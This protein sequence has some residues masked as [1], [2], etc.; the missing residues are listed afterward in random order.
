MP[1]HAGTNWMNWRKGTTSVALGLGLAAL[2]GGCSA[3]S[4]G[5]GGGGGGST[6]DGT[7]MSGALASTRVDHD[8]WSRLGYRLVWTGYAT[9]SPSD[10]VTAL[11]LFD[12]GIL[13]QDSSSVITD[14]SPVSGE[15]KW[16]TPVASPLTRFVGMTR[17]GKQYVVC[18][19]SEAFFVAADSGTLL[20]KQRFDRVVNT[21]PVNTGAL[22][23]MGTSGG[24]VIGHLLSGFKA[25]AYGVGG[26]FE[27]RPVAVGPDHVGLVSQNGRVIIIMPVT[28]SASAQY[29]I[30]GGVACELAASDRMLFVASVDQS[31]YGFEIYGTGAKWRKRTDSALRTTPTYHDGRLY[32][33]VPSA[34]LMCLEADTGRDIWTAKG[35][36]GTVIGKVKGRLLVWNGTEAVTLDAATGDVIERATLA[37]YSFLKPDRFVDGSIYVSTPKGAVHKFEVK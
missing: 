22:L 21:S 6:P 9:V 37:G 28:G 24:E 8:A 7:A 18:S 12:D 20:A 35:V 10:R 33:E 36:G 19:E 11:E 5:G 25:W 17:H 30:F 31:I 29:R 3:S 32:V 34:G 4:G 26:S 27:A 2:L 14:L 1:R 23:V 15:I 16:A 13:V